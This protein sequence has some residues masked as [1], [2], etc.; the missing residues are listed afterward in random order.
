MFQNIHKYTSQK[1]PKK[2]SLNH[3]CQ[4]S[5]GASLIY[6]SKCM[7][8]LA[9]IAYILYIYTNIHIK[10]EKT[11]E[12][13]SLNHECPESSGASERVGRG[14]DRCCTSRYFKIY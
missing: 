2:M 5:S 1:D 6:M 9:N 12:N 14:L 13:L 7:N 11:Q 10:T 4:E 8:I 3:E